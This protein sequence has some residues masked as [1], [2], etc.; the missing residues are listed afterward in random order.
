[1]TFCSTFEILKANQL[2]VKLSKCTFVREEV[3][4]LW[5]I[6][7]SKGV[8]TDLRK[9]TVMMEWPRPLSTRELRG[10]LGLIGYYWRFIK[11]YRIISKPLIELLKKG[12][13]NWN[14]QGE[15]AF[16]TLKRA[17]MQAPVLA[18]LDFSKPFVIEIDECDS[19]WWGRGAIL[20]QEGRLIAYI[21]QALVVRHLGMS[22][23]E[24]LL[25]MIV[26]IDKWRHYLEGTQFIIKT[27]HESLRHLLQQRLRTQLQRKG[28]SKLLGPDYI[29]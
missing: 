21:N 20:E 8:S 18:L 11:H 4:Y 9:I 15:A 27:N 24:E 13:F 17:M 6:I 22:V 14:P 5:H 28:V 26:A 1:M 7:S 10:F 23:Y 3:E 2:Y 25:A 12:N 16:L 29:I 19:V